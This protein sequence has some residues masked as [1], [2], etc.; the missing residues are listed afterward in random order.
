MSNLVL[1][2]IVHAVLYPHASFNNS[3]LQV[4]VLGAEKPSLTFSMCLCRT[5]LGHEAIKIPRILFPQYQFNPLG[6]IDKKY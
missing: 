4:Y 6:A 1:D 2:M 3:N 5:R